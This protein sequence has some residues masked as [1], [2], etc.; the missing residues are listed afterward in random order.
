M[1]I[2]QEYLIKVNGK[3]ATIKEVGFDET[4]DNIVEKVF[5]LT[6]ALPRNFNV[7]VLEGLLLQNRNKK[8]TLLALWL[9]QDIK[10]RDPNYLAEIT[11]KH[12]NLP[13]SF[14]GANKVS[15]YMGKKRVAGFLKLEKF[16]ENEL[17]N[18]RKIR[19]AGRG[20]DR[21]KALEVIKALK[22]TEEELFTKAMQQY[23]KKKE[24]F[25][26]GREVVYYGW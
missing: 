7:I 17:E 25:I 15:E 8:S 4:I 13:S 18:A 2:K 16:R 23:E 11:L 3:S 10:N 21:K 12:P 20:E 19:R 24:K 6:G 22:K 9:P 14:V 26:N 1:T 5:E